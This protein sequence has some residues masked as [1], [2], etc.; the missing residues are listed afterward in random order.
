MLD[1]VTRARWKA[2]EPVLDQ[3]LE[4]GP[5]SWSRYL[6]LACGGLRVDDSQGHS[7]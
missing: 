3:A 1:P 7:P 6:D 2:I 5:D 4:L